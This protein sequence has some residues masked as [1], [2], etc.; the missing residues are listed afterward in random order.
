MP[1]SLCIG[2][3]LLVPL[4]DCDICELLV[5]WLWLRAELYIDWNMAALGFMVNGFFTCNRRPKKV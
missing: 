3:P 4:M 1:F 2:L 5:C